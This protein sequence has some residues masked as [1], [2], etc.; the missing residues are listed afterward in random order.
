LRDLFDDQY[1]D[2]WWPKPLPTRAVP[3]AVA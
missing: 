2:R 3:R 1:E